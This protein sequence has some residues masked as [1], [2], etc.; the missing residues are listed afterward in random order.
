[1]DRRKK[2]AFLERLIIPVLF[3][4]AGSWIPTKKDLQRLNSLQLRMYRLVLMERRFPAVEDVQ[5]YYK[6]MAMISRRHMRAMSTRSW[7]CVAL[8]RIWTWA[9]HVQRTQRSRWV[10][11][12][13]NAYN[14]AFRATMRA[15][16]P[17]WRLDTGNSNYFA[18]RW[19]S[20]LLKVLATTEGVCWLDNADRSK[21]WYAENLDRFLLACFV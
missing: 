20:R 1:M 21:E 13:A 9:G 4:G 15:L 16:H 10:W 12:A 17:N 14:E 5:E 6:R 11:K 19:D 8:G 3:W 2:L 7:A 18:W